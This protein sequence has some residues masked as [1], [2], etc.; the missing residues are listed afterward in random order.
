MKKLLSILLVAV[1]LMGVFAVAASAA[2]NLTDKYAKTKLGFYAAYPK[3]IG[4]DP[5]FYWDMASPLQWIFQYILF[6]W[7]WMKYPVYK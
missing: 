3:A 6:G 7:A 1:V 4:E 5:P 2:T